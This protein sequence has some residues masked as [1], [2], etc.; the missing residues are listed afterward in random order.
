[1]NFSG[2]VLRGRSFR[3]QNLQGADFSHTQLHSVDFQG[4]N[5]TAANFRHAQTGRT[6]R[7]TGVLLFF[8][9][10]VAGSSGLIWAGVNLL[11]CSM[12]QQLYPADILLA[13]ALWGMV[14]LF[15]RI[16]LTQ[17]FPQG[18]QFLVKTGVWVVILAWATP[19]A[20]S[21]GWGVALFVAAIALLTLLTTVAMT[22]IVAVTAALAI[23]IT[24]F[25]AAIVTEAIAMVGAIAG[26]I[27]GV[28]VL[29]AGWPL[30]GEAVKLLVLLIT[31]V[32]VALAVYGGWQAL[33]GQSQQRWIEQLAVAVATWKG[34]TFQ[35]A[36]L[37]DADFAQGRLRFVDLRHSCL[38]RTHWHR[39]QFTLMRPGKTYLKDPVILQLVTRKRG[40]EQD[41][42]RQFLQ[43][44][45]LQGANLQ[46]A[47]FT[48]A[49]LNEAQLR[50]A[51]LQ[52]AILQQ[53]QLAG[54]DLTR[55]TLTGAYL[56]NWGVT[57]TTCIEDVICQY[58]YLRVP[59]PENP[60]P[61]RKPDN[62]QATFAPGEFTAF[63][64]PIT[65]TLDLYHTQ[66]VDP[67]A[68]ALAYKHLEDLHPEAQL[69]IVALEKRG[70][71]LLIRV[72]TAPVADRSQLNAEYFQNYQH[73]QAMAQANQRYFFS[74]KRANEASSQENRAS[75]LA[76]MIT[77]V[78]QTEDSTTLPSS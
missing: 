57:G 49:I 70:L 73:F 40:Q 45:N 26:V 44:V 2:Q 16:T 13:I 39:T 65:D 12:G 35:G 5:L 76:A 64:K 18:A 75:R 46:N 55:A 6:W 67:R 15:Y 72:K 28:N 38:L 36:N 66:G 50:E 71:N 25:S 63:M 17:G 27:L 32:E 11:F 62:Y 37:T 34:T 68:I 22:L 23:A 41:Y 78:L 10:V 54:T 1:M 58:I 9:L 47:N 21:G 74:E 20:G 3:G 56:E 24:G 8:S 31:G 29:S 52:G 51:N 4:A 7:W 19:F 61:H 14:G 42:Q 69:Q 77:T 33:S 30:L 53:T 48:G 60:N 59:T 43:G